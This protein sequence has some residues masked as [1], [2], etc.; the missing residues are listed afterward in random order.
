MHVVLLQI[1][2]WSDIAGAEKIE[3]AGLGTAVA[4]DRRERSHDPLHYQPG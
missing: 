1:Q 4:T 2:H 3:G